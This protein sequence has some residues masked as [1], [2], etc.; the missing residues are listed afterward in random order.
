MKKILLGSAPSEVIPVQKGSP[1]WE[2]RALL[3]CE[4]FKALL[5][6]LFGVPKT[7][8]LETIQVN[9]YPDLQFSH[10]ESDLDAEQWI[11]KVLR[12]LPEEWCDSSSGVRMV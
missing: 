3:E 10:E 7:G 5:Q 6:N 12:N 9:G 1:D 11:S 8:N 2:K 4:N